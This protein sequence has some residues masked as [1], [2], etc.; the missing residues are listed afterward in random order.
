[1]EQTNTGAA[2]PAKRPGFLNVLCI[3]SFIGTGLGIVFGIYKLVTAG[4]EQEAAAMLSGMSSSM[5]SNMGDVPGGGMMGDMMAGAV[6]MAKYAYVLAGLMIGT[7]ILCLLGVIQMWKLKKMGYY[8]YVVGQLAAIIVP[9]VLVGGGV[10][11]GIMLLFS[12]FQIAFIIMY[13]LNMK[14]MS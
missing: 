6:A 4:Q 1:M 14:H 11:G 2:M 7:N 9:L 13:G 10:M 5:G 8:L 12:V 3:L